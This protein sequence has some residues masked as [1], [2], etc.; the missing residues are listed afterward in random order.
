MAASNTYNIP[1]PQDPNIPFVAITIN[2]AIKLTSKNYLSWK[3]QLKSIL[4]GHNL[5]GHINGKTP[6]PPTTI[7][8]NNTVKNNPDHHTWF[9]QD[10]LLFGALIGTLSPNLTPLVS[11]A[12][13]SKDL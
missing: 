6:Q 12:I 7:T 5:I 13:T 4:I 2:N 8:V 9:R 10:Q 3:L 1:N 11:Q